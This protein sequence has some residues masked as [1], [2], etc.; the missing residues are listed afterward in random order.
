MNKSKQS[1]IGRSMHSQYH[2]NTATY[3]NIKNVLF[4]VLLLAICLIDQSSWATTIEVNSM[5]DTQIAQDSHCTLREAIENANQGSETTGGDCT[6]GSVGTDVIKFSPKSNVLLKLNTT[7][8]VSSNIRLDGTNIDTLILSGDHAT[9]VFEITPNTVVEMEHVTIAQGSAFEGGGILN[10]GH[11]IVIDSIFQYNTAH[12]GGGISNKGDLTISSSTFLN[13]VADSTGGGIENTGDNA[14]IAYS[15]FLNN[16]SALG[17]GSHNEGETSHLVVANTTF[18]NNSASTGGGALSNVNGQLTLVN[19][20]IFYNEVEISGQGGGVWNN[21]LLELKNTAIAHSIQGTD[22]F[23]QGIITINV[24][25]LIE[26]GSCYPTYIG[27]PYFSL[28]QFHE[29]KAQG[30]FPL[31]GSVAIGKADKATCLAFPINNLDQHQL[32]RVHDEQKTCDIGAL[33]FR[34][35]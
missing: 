27:D 24:R 15:I 23:N 16:S 31:K 20:T 2:K 33:E 28:L 14:L 3:Q 13:N 1:I 22:C 4:T 6:S 17:G 25:N 35:L 34:N 19:N 9:R 26:D 5:M 30:Y 7:L 8:V 10:Y 11:L 29:G 12:I 21:G 32:K 18:S